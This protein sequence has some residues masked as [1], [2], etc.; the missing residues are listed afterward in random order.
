MAEEK[1]DIPQIEQREGVTTTC[2]SM[3]NKVH[4]QLAKL[5]FYSRRENK[6]KHEASWYYEIHVYVYVYM[7]KNRIKSN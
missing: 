7:C 6:T 3:E 4:G 5:K 2:K 1:Q